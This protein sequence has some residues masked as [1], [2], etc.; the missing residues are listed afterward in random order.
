LTLWAK[1]HTLGI[2]FAWQ[3]HPDGHISVSLMQQSFTETLIDS[4]GLDFLNTSS[5][6]SP[7]RSGF[8][9]DFIPPEDLPAHQHDA[10]RLQYQSLVGS[11]NWLAHTTQPD[12]STVVSFFAQHQ[13]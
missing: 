2:E 9:I 3:H 10:L 12:L 4:L 11:P 8:P 6:A 1:F 5:Y 13:N 7:Y